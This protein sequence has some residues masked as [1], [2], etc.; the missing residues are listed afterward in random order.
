MA[1]K[2][3]HQYHAEDFSLYATLLEH[4]VMAMA[5]DH[6]FREVVEGNVPLESMS[7]DTWWEYDIVPERVNRFSQPWCLLY[8]ALAQ[9]RRKLTNQGTPLHRVTIDENLHAKIETR[10]GVEDITWE[11]GD[12]D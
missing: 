9:A 2:S 12:D 10:Y 4:K 3:K 8:E 1:L 11:P 6:F 5:L 7:T